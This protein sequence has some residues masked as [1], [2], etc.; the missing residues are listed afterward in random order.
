MK[1]S[2]DIARV[3]NASRVFLWVLL[4]LV[5]PGI[6]LASGFYSVGPEQRGVL[7]RFGRMLDDRVLPGMHYRLP[8]PIERVERLAT[9]AVRSIELDLSEGAGERLQGELTSGDL[10]L[11]AVA[12]VLQYTIEGPGDFQTRVLEP[13]SLLRQLTRAEAIQYVAGQRI[14]TLLTTGRNRLQSS[15]RQTLQAQVRVLRLGINVTSVQI[16]RLE[17]A[18]PVKR[19]FDEVA[20]ARAE[21]QKLIQMER[22]ERSSRLA[23]ARGDANQT[24]QRAQAYASERLEQARGDYAHFTTTWREYRRSPDIMGRRLYLETLETVLGRAR[25]TVASPSRVQ[26]PES[27]SPRHP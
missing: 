21:K 11:A 8:W 17:P 1:L 26:P 22:G 4:L 10:G 6:Y 12:L 14:D 23:R 25:V 24:L 2:E 3:L 15:P 27:S 16:K 20:A 13:E 18:E 7:Y 5:L 19:A 9:T